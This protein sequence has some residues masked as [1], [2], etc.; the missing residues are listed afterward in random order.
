LFGGFAG[1]VNDFRE[2]AAELAVMVNAG[3]AKVFK[4]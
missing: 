3:K 2:A 1:A 4:R